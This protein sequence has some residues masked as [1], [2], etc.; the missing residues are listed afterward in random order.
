MPSK[1]IQRARKFI[2]KAEEIRPKNDRERFR[3]SECLKHA[4]LALQHE[5]RKENS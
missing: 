5:V 2:A 3:R 4:I 1:N